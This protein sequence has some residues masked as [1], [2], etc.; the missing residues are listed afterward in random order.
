MSREL[1][2]KYTRNLSEQYIVIKEA[3]R[4]LR[5][6]IE[7]LPECRV[8]ALFYLPAP[9]EEEP[10]VDNLRSA[11]RVGGKTPEGARAVPRFGRFA[12]TESEIT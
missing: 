10:A 5:D 4:I 2:R 11:S 8:Y 7:V 1:R 12:G 6:I 3:A 9:D